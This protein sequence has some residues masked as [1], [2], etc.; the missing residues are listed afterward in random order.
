MALATHVPIRE[1]LARYDF[2]NRLLPPRASIQAARDYED[3]RPTYPAHELRPR[4]VSSVKKEANSGP[5]HSNRRSDWEVH[6][7]LGHRSGAVY[8]KY[9][10]RNQSCPVVRSR[11]SQTISLRNVLRRNYRPGSPENNPSTPPVI[12]RHVGPRH[13]SP[14]VWKRLQVKRRGRKHNKQ[15]PATATSMLTHTFWLTWPTRQKPLANVQPCPCR[16]GHVTAR[17]R[18]VRPLARHRCNLCPPPRARSAEMHAASVHSHT[19]TAGK[20]E[21]KQCLLSVRSVTDQK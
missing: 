8:A 9:S 15:Q 16:T 1:S 18:A 7:A 12:L 21:C 19:C 13:A 10:D 6:F 5:T 3:E 17:R 4:T 11:E 2:F 14:S 20:R